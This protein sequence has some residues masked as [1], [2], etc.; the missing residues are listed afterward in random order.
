MRSMIDRLKICLPDPQQIHIGK[1]FKGMS[2][3]AALPKDVVLVQCVED[4]YYLGL[5]GQIASSLREKQPFRIEQY[6]PRSQNVGESKS[7][8]TF[9]KSR[10][11]IN[12]LLGFKWERLYKSF[13]DSV[14]YRST[15]LR[16]IGDVMDFFRAWSC[17]RSLKTKES[18]VGMEI[19]GIAVGDL[20]NDTYLRFKPAPTVDLVDR[21][22]LILIWQAHRNVRR[23]KSYFARARPKLYLTSYSTYIQHGIPVRVALQYGVRVFSF[24]NYQEFAKELTLEDRVHTKNPDNYAKE[25]MKLD[26]Q[27]EKLALAEE[28]LSTRLS[29][30][31][32]G[33]TAYMKKSAYTESGEPVPNVRGAVVIFLHDFYDSPHVYREMVFP[34]FWEWVCFTIET[35]RQANIPC[36]LKPHPNQINLSDQVLSDLQEKYPDLLMISAG[37]TNRQL[38]E[39]GMSCA[40]TVYGTVAHEMAYMG[41]P[42]IACA[43]HPH[44]SFEF[45]KTARSRD[46]YAKLLQSAAQIQIDKVAMRRQSLVFY[47]MHN[48]A[49]PREMTILRSSLEKFR[50]ACEI[51]D[52]RNDLVKL[53]Q[54]MSTYPGYQ[55]QIL[56]MIG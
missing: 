45:C 39:A 11:V 42:T 43:H 16:P 15:S 28:A 8:L 47:Y 19:E 22:L 53:L 37:I 21:Y 10:W 27:D 40:V 50:S 34:D 30:G 6:V 18:L 48:L 38:A 5:F 3:N 25:F 56:G 7:I 49:L 17:W 55:T 41:V 44:I 54:Q 36:F 29:G 24:G 4:D 2:R 20:I 13:C 33:A 51:P 12:P 14:A 23:A 9:L 46:E 52:D 32:D 35:L 31:V 26:R 1:Y